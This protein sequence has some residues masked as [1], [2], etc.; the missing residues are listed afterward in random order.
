MSEVKKTTEQSTAKTVSKAKVADNKSTRTNKPETVIYIGPQIK[1]IV[2]SNM[3][4]NHGLPEVLKQ[5]AKEMPVIQNLIVPVK[6]LSQAK[7]DI[8]DEATA[9]GACYKK[10]V[11]L[12]K[13]KKEVDET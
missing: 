12:L 10:L 7:R 1:G 6:E 3:I 5:K 13:E 9:I 11:S 8:L 4:F 2:S